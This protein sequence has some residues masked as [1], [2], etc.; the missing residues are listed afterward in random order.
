LID[1]E[2]ALEK[3]VPR[4]TTLENLRMRRMHWCAAVLRSLYL[5][6]VGIPQPLLLAFQQSLSQPS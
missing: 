4:L 5:S 3:Y 2:E 1:S 6:F